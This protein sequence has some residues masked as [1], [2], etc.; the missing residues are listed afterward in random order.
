M[1]L[2]EIMLAHFGYGKMQDSRRGK[3]P[4]MRNYDAARIDRLSQSFLAPISTGDVEI[5][6]SLQ[7]IRARSRELERNND[8]AKKFINMCK[9][10]VVGKTGFILQNKARDPGPNGK[11]D[12]MANDIIE[13]E[14]QKWGK[15]GN[16]TVDGQ[17]SWLGE[18]ELFIKT[19]AR[20][21][22]FLGR[23]IRGYKNPWKFALQNL[24]ADL[25]NEYLNISDS[26]GQNLVKMGIEYDEWN[27]PL[28]Y[29]LRKKH[30]GD[31]F[32]S[33]FSAYTYERV[34]ASEIIHCFIPDRSTQ[35]RG[36]P[37]MHTAARRMNQ[38]GEYEYA[39]VVAARVAASKMG[40]FTKTDTNPMSV[41]GD[42]K[43]EKGN[44]ITDA[45]AGTFEDLPPGYDFKPFL[46]DHPT[47]QFGNFIKASL[48]GVSSGLN[49]S[50]NSLANDLENVNFSSMRSG[51]IEERDNWKQIQQWM[52]EGFIT[53]VFE[54][55]L[56]MLLLTN[57]TILPYAKYE[58]FN[59]PVWH[60]RIFDW[61]DPEKDI[62]A[63]IKM[64]RAGWK[65]NGKVVS[66]RMNMELE[67]V[68]EQLAE[69]KK[70]AEK[71]GLTLDLS[72]AITR[73][74]PVTESVDT[75]NPGG[76]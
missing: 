11:P 46:P 15:K 49:V 70:L 34:P 67:D 72:E 54:A 25:L 48:R 33:Q 69:E 60:G 30:P 29:H 75:A 19:V 6:N 73:R 14:W 44:F 3:S 12:K 74:P 56:D 68:Y 57:R 20:D 28:Y 8:Y 66:E 63:E 9:V 50:Y 58:K 7:I 40:F 23:I 10:N 52:I 35:G 37:W 13:S 59:S 22:E 76:V 1:S 61:V 65:T 47:T 39:E 41:M 53:Q 71:Y 26:S 64:V 45:E 38:V 17:V 62:D 2:L 24:E 32:R 4:R 18:Q 27:R 5:R 55:W 16:C 43:D 51:A 42:D 21:G 36:I 31:Y